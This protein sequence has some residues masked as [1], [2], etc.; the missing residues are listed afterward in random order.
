MQNHVLPDGV[1]IEDALEQRRDELEAPLDPEVADLA[2]LDV[3][4]PGAEAPL[5]A[6]AADWQEQHQVVEPDERDETKG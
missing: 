4:S 2:D 3:A 6:D 5:E 1:P